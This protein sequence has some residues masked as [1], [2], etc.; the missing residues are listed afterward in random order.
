MRFESFLSEEIEGEIRLLE[1]EVPEVFREGVVNAYEDGKE[2]V[3]EVL[4]GT[5]S[6][7]V[8]L[9]VRGHNLLSY[10]PFIL[11]DMLVFGAESVIKN[12]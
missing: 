2:V 10:M 9:Y 12:L 11:D 6:G 7:I 4:Y 3:L 1:E 8:T 5:F